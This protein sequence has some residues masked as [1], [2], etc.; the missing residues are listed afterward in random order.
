[1][2]ATLG[3]RIY[4]R[5][6]ELA[7]I[8]DDPDGLI[9]LYLSPA[10]RKAA[11][12]VAQWM[13]EA[14]MSVRIDAVGNVVGRREGVPPDAPALLIGSHI[15]TVSD[16]GRFDGCQGV[17]TAIS[18]VGELAARNAQYPFAMEVI[19]FGDEEGVRFASALG[20]SRAIAGSF[21]AAILEERDEQG[22]S[23]REALAAF[24][25]N[26]GAIAAEARSPATALG[27]VEVHIEQ[28][29]VLEAEDLPVGIV[30]AIS[31]ATRG[32]VEVHG[33]TG[34]A[35]TVP[36]GGRRDALAAAAEMILAVEA[37][38]KGEDDLV[39][40]V[41]RLTLTN[42]ATNTIAGKVRFS[43]DIRAP[44][45]A[46]RAV[47]VADI[48]AAIDRIAAERDVRAGV[49]LTYEAPAT[50]CD[51]HLMQLLADS[52][53]GVGIRA[54]QLP[55]GA[56]HDAMAFRGVLP[57]AMLFVRCGGGVSHHPSEHASA[58][59]IDVAAR[60]LTSFIDAYAVER[61]PSA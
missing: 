52:V 36:M 18:V 27:Y 51:P 13:R 42:A 20:G 41:G 23:R 3:E 26:P 40:T 19:A 58:A 55:S 43:L 54:R 45:D 29:P 24:G 50:P 48:Q 8:S 37:R 11:D 44:A 17:V 57:L 46:Q 10:H 21:D 22:I 30:T 12:L 35:G 33:E 14:G 2:T 9:R 31:G 32:F 60:V 5:I 7:R 39:A 56:G 61:R 34:H 53:E 49:S 15:D 59:D 47:A 25:C 16:A 1:M 4:S 38:A 6:G 28:G